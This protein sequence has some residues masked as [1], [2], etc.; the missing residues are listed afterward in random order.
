MGLFDDE[1]YSL[2]RQPQQYGNP[3]GRADPTQP[4]ESG[5]GLSAAFGNGPG[6]FGWQQAAE[7]FAVGRN[8]NALLPVLEMRHQRGRDAERDKLIKEK[9]DLDK[10]KS[11]W[12]ITK[13]VGDTGAIEDVE[14]GKQLGKIIAEKFGS[15]DMADFIG[16]AITSKDMR[17]QFEK[18][19]PALVK[20]YGISAV[21]KMSK[22]PAFRQKLPEMDKLA[23]GEDSFNSI[24]DAFRSGQIP[25]NISMAD[26]EKKFPGALTNLDEEK[27]HALNQLGLK[28]IKTKAIA[29]AEAVGDRQDK[30]IAAA[31]ERQDKSI[32][33][34][35]ERQDRQIAVTMAGQQATNDRF[36]AMEGNR[37][38]REARLQEQ[39][40]RI[41]PS[42]QNDL[43]RNRV[44]M[45]TIDDF[46]EAYEEFAKESGGSPMSEVLRGAVAKNKTAQ[47]AQDL[48]TVTGRTPAEIKFAAK[49]NAIIGN[50]RTQ[51][52]EVGVM[53]D[54]DA[55]RIMRSFD[56]TLAAPQV[57]ANLRARR[58]SHERTYKTLLEDANAMG[59]DVSKFEQDTSP[60]KAGAP[61]PSEVEA[62]KKRLGITK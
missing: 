57:R 12:E 16:E 60:K 46:T 54:I 34:Q 24:A 9:A 4:P 7:S 11:M 59:K 40:R 51:T 55:E 31:G 19:V 33:A 50:M 52:D 10:Y 39:N 17:D 47:R 23:R 37:D 58:Q 56:P 27:Q 26:L 22:D 2:M 15:P 18:V 49:Y 42:Q 21:V 29:Q 62:A 61:A 35:S 43:T 13:Q 44:A 36:L 6:Q 41:L 32:A 28:N 3:T 14:K 5:L 38:A 48:A 30:T 25:A 1:D 20:K 53:T 8:P 45:K